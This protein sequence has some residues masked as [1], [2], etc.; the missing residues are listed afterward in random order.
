MA[1]PRR[2]RTRFVTL[3]GVRVPIV[4]TVGSGGI[5][6]L[7]DTEAARRLAGPAPDAHGR[8]RPG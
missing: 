8:D 5:V 1:Q 2:T 6:T 4:G 7:F 3:P